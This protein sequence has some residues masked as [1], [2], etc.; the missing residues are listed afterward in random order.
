M[1]EWRHVQLGQ[2]ADVRVSNVDKK[3]LPGE[4]SVQ[5][6]N[7]MDVYSND[8]IRDDL[9]FM[10]AS[11]TGAEVARFKVECGDVLITKD[12]ETPDDIG[13]PAVV[14]SD[15]DNLVCGY[16]VA[17]IK[18]NKSLVDSVYLSKQL[19]RTETAGYF[20][21]YAAGS[22]RYGLPIGAITR[23]PLA[24][25]PLKQQ[26][27]IAAILS[28]IDTAIEQTEALIE[29]YQHIKAGLMHDL[30]TR[31]VLPDGQ[32]RPPR[33]QAPEL[34]QETAIGWI[35]KEWDVAALETLLAPV[36][37]N[38]RSGPFGSA[39]LKHE[40][41]EEGIPFLGID[42]IHVERFS[43]DFQRFV[44]ERK[45]RELARYRVRP[46]DVIITIMGTVG[47]CCVVPA[48]IEIALSS[49]HLW[50]MTFDTERIIPELVCWQLNHAAW[51]QAWFRKSM[52][53]GIMDAIQSSTLKTLVVPLPS[54]AEQLSIQAKF[55][56]VTNKINQDRE[57]LQKLKKQKLGL[58]QD[59]LTGKVAVKLDSPDNVVAHA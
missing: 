26:R 40:L 22:T 46:G 25:A 28:T 45:F 17:L 19:G 53:G 34:Y 32:P 58:M 23:A 57:Q 42:N 48:A 33:D 36:P 7:Y 29:K 44:S 27:K 51:A 54:L 55:Q 49:K 52:Q 13:I 20:S 5:L 38:I 6:C 30:F 9:T 37:N 43:A 16:H 4:Q 41:V 14:I 47:R 11:A 1:S 24:L 21:R 12:S 31:G 2:I 15:I 35:P 59:L 8:Y 18:P 10:T 39:L 56:Q 50:T 3:T